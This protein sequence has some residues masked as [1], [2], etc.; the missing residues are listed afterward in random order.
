MSPK[1]AFFALWG[2]ILFFTFVGCTAH[3]FS[4]LEGAPK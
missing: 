4:I 1:F 3:L 2:F